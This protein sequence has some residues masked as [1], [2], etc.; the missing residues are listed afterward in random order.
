MCS[1]VFE[2]FG[3]TAEEQMEIHAN[4]AYCKDTSQGGCF[5]FSTFSG[6]LLFS[7]REVG[8]SEVQPFWVTLLGRAS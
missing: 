8:S 7:F 6:H 1:S 4:F 3:S 2:G 5:C